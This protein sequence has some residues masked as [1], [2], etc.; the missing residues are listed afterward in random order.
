MS[1]PAPA[2]DQSQVVHAPSPPATPPD[3]QEV[4]LV[5]PTTP[6]AKVVLTTVHNWVELVFQAFGQ[7]MPTAATEIAILGV[8]GA[9]LTGKGGMDQLEAEAGDGET[10][11]ETTTR[12]TR[13]A[14][15]AH[16][17]GWNDLIFIASTD[18]TPA[19][20]QHVDV[21]ECTIDAGVVQ[22]KLGIPITLEGKLYGGHPGDHH[23]DKYPGK[24]VCLHLYYQSISQMALARECT[25]TTRTF[26]TVASAENGATDWRFAGTEPDP[27]IHMHF[28]LEMGRVGTWSAGCTV[29]HHHYWKKVN[30]RNVIDPAATRYQRFRDLF[31]GAANKQKIPYLVVSSQYV[32]S[33]AEWVRVLEGQPGA[34]VKAETVIMK[35]KLRADPGDAGRYLASFVTTDFA[36]AVEA[37]AAK[38]TT[39]KTHAANLKSSMDLVTFTLSI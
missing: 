28:G 17:P 16:D 32:R 21:F 26:S 33:Y 30:G 8:R 14:N 37:L 3:Q 7:T 20:T 12:L 36:T 39:S 1:D 10:D 15:F 2:P 31:L 6:T 9:S 18:S 5:K 23:P 35:D 38:S 29:L 19:R 24:D 22:S 13:D 27:G 4:H 11:K 34:E 25:K